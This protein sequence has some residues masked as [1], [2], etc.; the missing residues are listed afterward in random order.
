MRNHST[1]K[2][3][4]ETKILVTGGSGKLGHACKK[5]MPRAM[6]PTRNELD[7]KNKTSVKNYFSKNKI[8]RVV[9]LAA[10]VGIR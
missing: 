8:E 9:H 7:I 4:N 5:I 6:F 2:Q 3:I 10:M 1:L